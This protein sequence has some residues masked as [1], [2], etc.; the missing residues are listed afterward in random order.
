MNKNTSIEEI[1]K[2]R[3]VADLHQFIVNHAAKNP[4]FEKAFLT[5]FNPQQ[6][7]DMDK[8]DYADTIADA[9]ANN[10]PKGNSRYGRWDDD[11][12]DAEDVAND[13]QP[14]LDKAAYYLQHTNVAEAILICQ[15]L[16]ETIPDEW[17]SDLDYDGD[18][19]VIYDD[20]INK[21]QEMMDG[22]L[23]S[24]SQKQELFDWYS[25]EHKDAKHEYVGLNTNLK[26]LEGFFT[27]TPEMLER[28]LANMEDRIKNADADY[29]KQDAVMSKIRLL[30]NAGLE[31]EAESAID[32]YIRFDKVRKLRMEKLMKETQYADAIKLIQE[33]IKIALEEQ[34]AG[35]VNRWK[36]EL[37]S[38]YK[39]QD[40]HDKILSAAEELFYND[41]NGNPK[42]YNELKKYTPEKDWPATLERLLSKMDNG[43]FGFN[44][45]KA[46]MLIEHKMW[47]RLL[48]LCQ[49]AGAQKLEEY[50]KYLKPLY[51]KEIF[52][53][54]YKYV[55]KQALITD[56]RAY[57][58]VARVLRKMKGYEGGDIIVEQL[59][60]KYR[61][62]YKR[63]KNMM[64]ELEG[65]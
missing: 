6:A 3:D 63:R 32:Q 53:A 39:L 5:N 24:V 47:E 12:F 54:Y 31:K 57:E 2:Y 48:A 4:E 19:Q 52:D 46:D 16:I 40:N 61:E 9:F 64:K 56:L 42:Y 34:Y 37:L 13:L 45:L 27:D 1:L 23:L 14:L 15:A 41:P 59:L 62:V 7:S 11:G 18:V 8:A 10:R 35:T 29:E 21:L 33:G 17:E 36:E 26:A 58:N 22:N 38:I 60:R 55:E 44:T 65:V 50:E 43:Y 20:A 28:S 49:K 30:Q 51:A 25:E